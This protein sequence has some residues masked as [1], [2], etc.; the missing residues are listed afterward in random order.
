MSLRLAL[1]SGYKAFF[2]CEECGA[3]SPRESGRNVTEA[4]RA[5]VH[6]A[7]RDRWFISSDPARP[8]AERATFCSKHRDSRVP[9]VVGAIRGV[10]VAR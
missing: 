4:I 10:E 7:L 9:K 6:S 2:A 5:A 3:A 1:A 8:V